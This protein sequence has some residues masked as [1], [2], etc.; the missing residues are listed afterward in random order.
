MLATDA[1]G[2]S[3]SAHTLRLL[4]IESEPLQPTVSPSG[5]SDQ[6]EVGWLQIHKVALTKVC[7]YHGKPQPPFKSVNDL[8][9]LATGGPYGLEVIRTWEISARPLYLKTKI[10]LKSRA[11]GVTSPSSLAHCN[12]SL[13]G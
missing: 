7:W 10:M 9:Q 3:R 6:G 11:R 2:T 4:Y 8:A 12:L 1:S 5:S 13:L